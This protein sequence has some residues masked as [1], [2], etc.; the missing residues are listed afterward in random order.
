[1]EDLD[2]TLSSGL[3]PVFCKLRVVMAAQSSF[4]FPKLEATGVKIE[5]VH[6]GNSEK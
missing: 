4:A 1:M 2:E 3:F 6:H 5:V